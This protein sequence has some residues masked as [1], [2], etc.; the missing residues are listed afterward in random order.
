ME[1]KMPT[2]EEV[3]DTQKQNETLEPETTQEETKIESP[4]NEKEI[5]LEKT[6]SIM[7]EILD[8]L[9]NEEYLM[10]QYG[11]H[12]KRGEN[13]SMVEIGQLM[14]LRAD[15]S[16]CFDDF[17]KREQNISSQK[18]HGYYAG[19]DFPDDN[20]IDSWVSHLSNRNMTDF[21]EKQK[22]FKIHDLLKNLKEVCDGL[23]EQQDAKK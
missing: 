6:I 9:P 7:K 2:P 4:E 3:V 11:A 1:P 12:L 18:Y 8:V 16:K 15:L 10:E 19:I 22:K 13:S 20:E 23:K 14:V 5:S 21:F 17:V